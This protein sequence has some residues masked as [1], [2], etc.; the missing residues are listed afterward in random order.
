MSSRRML[1]VGE[2]IRKVVSTAITTE[3]RDP[4][5]GMATV[6]EVEVSGD[7][8]FAKVKVSILGDDKKQRLGLAG[9]QSA[10]GFLQSKICERLD[11]RFTPRIT[12]ELDT[13]VKKSLEVARILREVLPDQPAGV[14]PLEA[15]APPDDVE[16]ADEEEDEDDLD[17]GWDEDSDDDLTKSPAP[18]APQAP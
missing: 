16:D 5:I 2:A 17:E 8:R 3:L 11:M 14:P 4:R 13:G 6:T 18:E 1:K 12:F 7:L 9:L 10:A 15:A